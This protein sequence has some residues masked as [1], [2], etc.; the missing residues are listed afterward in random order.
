MH[1]FYFSM[2]HCNTVG[3]FERERDPDSNLDSERL[4]YSLKVSVC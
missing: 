3:Q 4:S 2:N 1:V